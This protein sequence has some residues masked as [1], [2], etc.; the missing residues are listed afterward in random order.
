MD[1]KTSVTG[2]EQ[3]QV[4]AKTRGWRIAVTIA[5]GV[6]SGLVFLIGGVDASMPMTVV[7]IAALCY[8]TAAVTGL[9]WM[10]W[11]FVAIGSV[12]VFAAELADVPRWIV[13]ALAGVVLVA[14][15]LIKRRAA[16]TT[17]Q[18]LAMLGYFG[19]AVV[20]LF[21]APTVGLVLAGLA[22]AAHAV[23]D[24]VHYRRDVVVNRSLALWCIGLD[25]FLGTACI[26]LAITA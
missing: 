6:L 15:G 20:A 12:L 1:F 9:R 16:A 17:P 7:G 14:I 25:V 23:W 19:V 21:L 24:V 18:A 10:A 4:E 2:I 5:I 8:L 22:L 13:L 11:A 3:H 26:V